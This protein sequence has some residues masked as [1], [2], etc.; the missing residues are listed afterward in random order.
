M[1]DKQRLKRA[2]AALDAM[3]LALPYR[4]VWPIKMRRAYGR[5]I[6]QLM[7]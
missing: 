5:V 3:V 7:Q 1:T 4:F 2:L 6:K